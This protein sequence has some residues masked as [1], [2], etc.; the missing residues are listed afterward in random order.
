MKKLS[1]EVQITM[2]DRINVKDGQN[3][4]YCQNTVFYYWNIWVIK[5][6]S[7]ELLFAR[8]IIN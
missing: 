3:I 8:A 5:K 7:V 2:R 6:F 4:V 1:L